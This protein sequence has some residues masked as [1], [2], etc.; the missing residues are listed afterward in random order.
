MSHDSHPTPASSAGSDALPSNPYERA[1]V[2]AEAEVKRLTA[3][4]SEA[5]AEREEYREDSELSREAIR[6]LTE[7]IGANN[8]ELARLREEIADR[9]AA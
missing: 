1:W 5:E 2:L 3:A 4:L 6:L 7:R 8:A 9:G